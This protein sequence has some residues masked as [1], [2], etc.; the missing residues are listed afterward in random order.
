MHIRHVSASR[1]ARRVLASAGIIVLALGAAACSS[2]DSGSGSSDGTEEIGVALI[3]KDSANP[4]W[5]AMQ[6]GAKQ[7]AAKQNVALTVASG[8]QDGDEQ[9]QITAVEDAIARGDKGILISPNGPG[10][11]AAIKKARDAGPAGRARANRSS[12][13]PDGRSA[14]G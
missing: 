10:V 1:T 5:V 13:L 2:D 9:G 4:F 3:T 6:T 8:K 12:P 14:C 11:N 7:D